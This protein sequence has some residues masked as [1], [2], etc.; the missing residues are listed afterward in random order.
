MSEGWGEW[1]ILYNETIDI[2]PYTFT[3][4]EE[5]SI[6]SKSRQR[7]FSDTPLL[8]MKHSMWM[9]MRQPHGMWWMSLTG[10]GMQQPPNV[11]TITEICLTAKD[12][13]CIG[14]WR[15][16]YNL[17]SDDLGWRVGGWNSDTCFYLPPGI[18]TVWWYAED[19]FNTET[20]IHNVTF[21]VIGYP[22]ADFT[23]I[24]DNRSLYP[25]DVITFIANALPD[26]GVIHYSWDFG[27]GN[28]TAGSG[29]DYRIVTHS[30][31][32]V[33]NKTV[34]LTITAFGGL[35]TGSW[36]HGI[37]ICTPHT[38][39]GTPPDADFYW[40]PEYPITYENIT[41]HDNS[42]THE[43]KHIEY[44]VW[45]FGDGDVSYD[46]NPVHYYENNGTYTVSL[47]VYDNMSAFDKISYNITVGNRPPEAL[48][49]FSPPT[50]DQNET[51]TFNASASY[52]MDGTIVNYTWDFGDGNIGYGM[53]VTHSYPDKG[54]YTVILLVTDDDGA[55]NF[56]THDV[57]VNITFPEAIFT[58]T[59]PTPTPDDVVTFNA[60][61]SHDPDG[62]I[63]NWTWDF[64]DG[65]MGYGEV[66]THQYLTG[67]VYPV[68][69]TVRDNNG[70]ENS[71]SQ[72]VTVYG[73]IDFTFTLYPGWNYITIPVQ[74]SFTA[75]SLVAA[76]GGW[77]V[78]W[79][80]SRYN[81]TPNMGSYDDYWEGG[82][83]EVWDF[84]I[85]DGVG[86]W[87]YINNSRGIVNFTVNGYPIF[88]VSVDLDTSP[89]IK[90]TSIG[91][92]KLA[93]IN[94]SDLLHILTNTTEEFENS[95]TSIWIN[96]GSYY[97]WKTYQP[98]TPFEDYV[99]E[100]GMGV[101]VWL[102]TGNKWEE[103][104]FY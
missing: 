101:M 19:G 2:I 43:G 25:L 55:M 87:I 35:L 4:G 44:Y 54:I 91:W 58:Y 72:N 74:N 85:E 11:S 59:P 89:L 71:T 34:T 33:G 60:S 64:G 37:I 16:H 10:E 22:Y 94:A 13:G 93:N 3:F 52:D 88:N 7:T 100:T 68:T 28:G 103:T 73:K 84:P 66:V 50:P 36:S 86:Y 31:E 104:Q 39:P 92:F 98:D 8:T 26:E 6:T 20:P 27:D 96:N 80:V 78:V 79:Q 95:S 63:V 41:F 62:T 82:A 65:H 42:T 48:F 76:I 67:G 18:H 47:I 45:E 83:G 70:A 12:I 14:Q 99:I 81:S 29:M 9:I 97:G 38:S 69:L 57:Y 23:W 5:C 46:A 17:S 61:D 53:V 1:N 40:T 102:P 56:T 75:S 51:V 21:T 90:F 77:D 32:D 24:P 49:S 15:I 30:Y